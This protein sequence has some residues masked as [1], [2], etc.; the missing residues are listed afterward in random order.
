M[1]DRTQ[2][3]GIVLTQGSIMKRTFGLGI[4]A[5]IAVAMLARPGFAED[6]A[7]RVQYREGSQRGFLVLRSQT[8]A[9]LASGEITQ[10]PLGDRIKLRLV[11]HFRDG[12]LSDETTVYS[13]NST[14]RLISDRLVQSGKSF[15]NPCEMSIDAGYQ[16]V[17]MRSLAKGGE[18]AK[19]EHMDL[20]P[21]LSN[22][23]LFNLIKNLPTNV[24]GVKISY[25]APETKPRMV[26]L[27]IALEKEE[28]FTIAGRP[29]KAAEWDV[30]PDLGGVAGIVA[31]MV[32]KQPPDTHVWV[33]EGGIPVVVRVD[34][35]LYPDGPVWSIQLASPAW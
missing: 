15:P 19:T 14:F 6:Q 1:A 28:Q 30:K 35:A 24:P 9:I 33:A 17:S 22:G 21:D 34:A 12:S 31:P 10:I 16:Q 32:G 27:A 3:I 11:F 7:V 20:P 23:L 26:K 2:S 18:A 29:V 5:L 4:V 13:Q 25:L 8:G